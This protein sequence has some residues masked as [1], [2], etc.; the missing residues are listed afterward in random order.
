MFDVWAPKAKF[1]A[2]SLDGQTLPMTFAGGGWW[3]APADAAG[4][5]YGYL[6]DDATTPVPDPRS[7]RQPDGV[8]GLSRIFSAADHGWGDEAW[9]GRQLAG[10]TIYELHIGTF[11]LEGTLDSAIERLDH[12]VEL[13]IDFVEVLPVNGFNGTHNWGYDGVLWYTVQETYGGPAAYQRFVD[14]CHQR[15]LAVIQ[16]VV[17]N[18]L[19]PSGN[20]LP[21][22]GPYLHEAAANTWGSS[23]NLDGEDSDEV[24][25]YVIDNALMWL[26]D[27]HVDGLRLDAVHALEDHRAVH[28]LEELSEE[29]DALSAH[30]GRPLSLI[31]ESDLNDPRMIRPREA[32]GF[33]ITAQWSDD[34]H[35]SVHVALT[36]ETTGYYEDFESI[37]A[38]AT[39]LERGFFHARSLSTFRG[40][41]HG[42][43]I[44][45]ETTPTWRLVVFS[46]DHDQIGNRAIGDRLSATLDEN[47]LA[48]AAVLTLTSPFT[49]MLFMGE[50]WGATTP[51]QFFTSHPEKDLGE[52][53][54]KGRIAEFAKMGW[55]PSV[56]P[57]PQDPQ[58]FANS[59]LDWS[60]PYPE[61]A[62]GD[63]GQ[64]GR[65][66]ALYRELITLRR[67]RPELTDPRFGQVTVEYDADARWLVLGRG[68]LVIALNLGDAPLDLELAGTLLLTTGS[69]VALDA[70]LSLPARTSAIVDTHGH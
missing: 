21:Q 66:L 49:P 30:L 56:V 33:G 34:F 63:G 59:K 9:T 2:L 15:G 60:E 50:E 8:H 54:A 5:D 67:A 1:V 20:Y 55:D 39:V 62:T 57:D 7:R 47:G 25:H 3:T 46:Q 70:H 27:Y 24:R 11:T 44:E 52:A 28:I 14:A 42:R 61:S 41:V 38:L 35:H 68:H 36:G 31:A 6:I 4:T 48:L 58:T 16:D 17:Y 64:H 69:G 29:V 51:W 10:G 23:L 22:F 53:T 19:G 13:G 40:R 37:E 65:L 18:H 26:R 32:H 12:L 45:R 43:A